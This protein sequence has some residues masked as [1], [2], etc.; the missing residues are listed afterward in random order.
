MRTDK[1]ENCVN[2]AIL[3]SGND[4]TIE[5]IIQYFE[6][7][8]NA[9]IA[10][11]ITNKN[12]QD[13]SNK[14]RRYKVKIYDNTSMYKDIDNILSDHNVHYIVLSGY[15]DKIPLNFCRKYQYKIINLQSS[16]LPTGAG[17]YGD[18]LF[19]NIK[20]S[21]VDKT[22]ISVHFVEPEYNTGTVIFTNDIK[23][24]EEDT[25]EDIKLKTKIIEN[26]YYPKVI[27][28]IIKGTYKYLYEPET[29]TYEKY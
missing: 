3:T 12:G 8:I 2:I 24:L 27:E 6:P 20:K 1:T 23:I 18:D 14:L 21:G 26:K 10:C 22:G 25:W 15:L 11:V 29:E 17:M 28:K 9:N 19:I 5:S 7:F 13:I 4:E 16:L